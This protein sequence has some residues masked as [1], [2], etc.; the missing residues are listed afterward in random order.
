MKTGFWR[1]AIEAGVISAKQAVLLALPPIPTRLDW[2]YQ[3]HRD[4]AFDAK[5]YPQKRGGESNPRWQRSRES[6]SFDRRQPP[7]RAAHRAIAA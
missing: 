5:R 6:C 1:E 3:R 4:S 7:D 2:R